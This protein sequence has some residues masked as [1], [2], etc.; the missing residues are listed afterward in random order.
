ME[1]RLF[2]REGVS[3][4]LHNN[5]HNNSKLTT[6][7]QRLREAKDSHPNKVSHLNK[8]SFLEC[9]IKGVNKIEWIYRK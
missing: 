3:G 8:V 7:R 5:R 1:N 9:R 2:M 6:L 4:Q